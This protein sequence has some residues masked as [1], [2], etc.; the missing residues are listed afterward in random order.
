MP[1]DCSPFAELIDEDPDTYG[2]VLDFLDDGV[3][4]PFTVDQLET[5]RQ[6]ILLGV[7]AGRWRHH[8]AAEDL[9]RVEST[10]EFVGCR[11]LTVGCTA[12]A[13]RSLLA[14]AA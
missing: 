13:W 10:I 5:A 14:T 1:T 2:D 7:A 6:R 8:D 3:I 9:A 11:D 4:T 12:E